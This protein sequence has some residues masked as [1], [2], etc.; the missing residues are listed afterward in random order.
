[1]TTRVRQARWQ[2]ALVSSLIVSLL[3]VVL[4]IPALFFLAVVGLGFALVGELSSDPDRSGEL[5]LERSLTETRVH[6]GQPVTVT[7]SVTNTG[8]RVASDVRLVD[9]PPDDIPVTDG[10]PAFATAVQPGETVHHEYELTPPRGEFEFGTPTVRCRSLPATSLV[11]VEHEADG[12]RSFTCETLLDTV[13][14]QDRTIQFVG[15]TPTDDGGS[16]IEFFS[17]RE[18]R[19]GD[20]INRIDWHRFA[21]TGDLTTVEYREERTVTIVF[22]IDDRVHVH[23]TASDGGPTSYD[24]TLQAASRGVVTSLEDGNRTGLATLADDVWIEPGTGSG[25]RTQVRKAIDDT[26]ADSAVAD[27]GSLA[28]EL[29]RRLPHRAQVVLCTPV[30]D[31]EAVDIVASLRTQGRSV[32]VITPDMTTG[33]VP[34]ERSMGARLASL[35]RANRLDELRGLGAT[36]IDWNLEEPIS[37]SLARTFRSGGRSA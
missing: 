1:M 35:Q 33:V 19:H 29:E 37:V 13:A 8:D 9:A 34:S 17:T 5:Q 22:V 15:Q 25:V 7:L 3:A 12:D 32:T 31:A 2:S 27:G 14:F 4:G 30:T 18:Y 16:G 10:S 26:E 23:R 24:L 11:T 36:V 28:V 21:R 6:P 20:P